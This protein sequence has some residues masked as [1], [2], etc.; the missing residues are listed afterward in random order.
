MIRFSKTI[1]YILPNSITNIDMEEQIKLLEQQSRLLE[2]DSHQ[3]QEWNEAVHSYADNFLEKIEEH[4]TYLAPTEKQETLPFGEEGKHIDAL[5]VFLEAHTD[6]YGLNP[7]APRHFG[8]IPG[9]GVMTTA[10]GDYLAGITNRYAGIFFA[11]P[12]AVTIE[13]QLIRW[14]CTMMGYPKEALGNLTSGGSIAN[15]TAIITARDHFAL[16]AADYPKAVVYLTEHVHHCIQKALRLGGMAEAIIRYIPVDERFKM[17]S[18]ELEKQIQEDI[19]KG[20]RPFVLVGNAGTTN[21]GTID[22]LDELAAL[23]EQYGLWYH[24]DAAYGGF[25]VLLENYK[26]L[27]KGIER[28]HSI[29][30]DPHKGLFLSYGSGALLV[31]DPRPLLQANHY[32]ANY[33]QDASD[34]MAAPSPADLSPELTKHFRGLRMWIT[35]HLFGLKPLKASMEE[36]ILLCRYFYEKIQKQGFEVGPYPELS[37][38][39]FRY[40]PGNGEAN[41]FN[42]K[43]VDYTR[44][45][46]R[47]FISTTTINGIYWL[48]MAVMNFRTHLGHIDD[49]L[50][51]LEKG[52]RAVK[53]SMELTIR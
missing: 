6:K 20:L 39:I 12:G 42:Q 21:T 25:F 23:A 26:K 29:T 27:F 30:I 10:L 13:N 8:Y 51:V 16:K 11:G 3:R 37:V 52:V 44:Q 31:R 4:K 35:L 17:K 38:M 18:D 48:R 43:L 33:M 40:V 2:P 41:T 47:I 1:Q 5:L 24:V 14:M 36:K 49:C 45:D 34:Y 53:K 22:P 15:M 19:K 46:G 32:T 28:S 7:A 9:G 50:G